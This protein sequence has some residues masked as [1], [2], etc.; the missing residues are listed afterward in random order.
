M[1]KL[2]LLSACL[3][4]SII[5]FAQQLTPEKVPAPVRQAFEKMF[6]GVSEIKYEMENKAYEIS[7]LYK[8]MKCSA[9]FDAAGAWLETETGIETSALPKEVTDAVAKNF[10]GYEMNEVLKLE[11]P[12][13]EMY[14]ELG[15]K[16]D[17]AS[18]EVQFSQKGDILKKEILKH[19]K[20][21]KK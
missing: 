14:Y 13:K 18:F 4:A 9:N 17:K 5:G 19:E 6:P 15:L 12:G 11:R 2:T 1:K 16:K 10:A 3:L 7:F 20:E 21:V 8:R